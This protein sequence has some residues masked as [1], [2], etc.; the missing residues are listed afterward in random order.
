MPAMSLR[1]CLAPFN[2]QGYWP[3]DQIWEHIK[4]K[5]TYPLHSAVSSASVSCQWTC[6]IQLIAHH[7]SVSPS[8]TSSR[9]QTSVKLSSHSW[10][11]HSG[12]PPSMAPAKTTRW[13]WSVWYLVVAPSMLLRTL[14]M[15]DLACVLIICLVTCLSLNL[16]RCDR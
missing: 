8:K 11:S 12:F 3:C 10:W 4:E 1:P 9:G 5:V 7:P 13:L 16:Y 14:E 15:V 6:Q 2:P